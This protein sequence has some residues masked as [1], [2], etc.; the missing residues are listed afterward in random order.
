MKTFGG[1]Q[2]TRRRGGERSRTGV[3]AEDEEGSCVA[4][5]GDTLTPPSKETKIIPVVR[6]EG[7]IPPGSA[8]GGRGRMYRPWQSFN[9]QD[10]EGKGS[11]V[12]R[13]GYRAREGRERAIPGGE[14]CEGGV[15]RGTGVGVRVERGCVR[16][17]DRWRGGGGVSG[18][19]W[20]PGRP[21]TT[22]NPTVQPGQGQP[23]GLRRQ[24]NEIE[25]QGC[26]APG[27][28]RQVR[29]LIRA[30]SAGPLGMRPSSTQRR[31]CHGQ[32]APCTRRG[33][34]SRRRNESTAR[35]RTV[36]V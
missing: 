9:G 13:M 25:G 20:E 15:E 2:R 18:R 30:R 5:V 26:A 22:L 24:Q 29:I 27:D 8:R 36:E 7:L 23:H 19:R 33:P 17:V 10:T 3:S 1:C 35:L 11:A 31:L 6:L 14:T 32:L 16:R 12:S 21:D 4:E 34:R 28:L